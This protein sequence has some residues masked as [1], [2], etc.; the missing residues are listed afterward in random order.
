M[1]FCF[2][3]LLISPLLQVRAQLR[4]LGA[5]RLQRLLGAARR[6]LRLQQLS[7]QRRAPLSKR[8]SNQIPFRSNRKEINK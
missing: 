3:V 6:A 8:L 1:S 5:L 4:G 2:F 7:L